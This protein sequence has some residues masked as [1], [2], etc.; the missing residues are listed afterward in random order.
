MDWGRTREN[1]DSNAGDDDFVC[2][3]HLA[4][5][6]RAFFTVALPSFSCILHTAV[7]N[8]DRLISCRFAMEISF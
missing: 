4:A 6:N 5:L 1:I 3:P 7:L 8:L 2:R